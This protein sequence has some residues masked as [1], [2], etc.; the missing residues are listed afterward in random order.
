LSFDVGLFFLLQE[1]A[2]K[3][4]KRDNLKMKEG[5]SSEQKRDGIN[6]LKRKERITGKGG[7]IYEREQ[8]SEEPGNGVKTKTNDGRK[9]GMLHSKNKRVNLTIKECLHAGLTLIALLKD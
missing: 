3:E 8:G 2:R 7:R 9:K 4:R 1:S 6:E 5:V